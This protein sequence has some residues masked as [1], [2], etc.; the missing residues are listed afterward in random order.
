MPEKNFSTIHFLFKDTFGAGRCL[1][2]VVPM[3]VACKEENCD[4][5]ATR[6]WA[7]LTY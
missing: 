3:R 1:S 4:L 5:I 6:V 2:P 7:R